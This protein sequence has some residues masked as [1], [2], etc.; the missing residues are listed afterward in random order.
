MKRILSLTLALLLLFSLCSCKKTDVSTSDEPASSINNSPYD[1]GE[2]LTPD[3]SELL[4]SENGIEIYGKNN[5]SLDAPAD[6]MMEVVALIKNTND[7]DVEIVHG[8]DTDIN[9]DNFSGSITNYCNDFTAIV[10]PNGSDFV[11]EANSEMTFI[12]DISLPTFNNQDESLECDMCFT[13]DFEFENYESGDDVANITLNINSDIKYWGKEERS[14]SENQNATIKGVIVDSNN[15]PISNVEIEYFNAI[16]ENHET[17]ISDNNGVFEFK[18]MA[19][20][21]NVSKMWHECIVTFK[22]PSYAETSVCAYPKSNQTTELTIVLDSPSAT[23]NYTEVST[24]DLGIQAYSYDTDSNNS[25]IAFTPFHS[26]LHYDNIKNK[27]NLN[28]TDYDGNLLFKYSLNAETPWVCVSDDGKYVVTEQ[29]ISAGNEKSTYII[30]LDENGK[31]V[32]KKSLTIKVNTP[33]GV[34]EDVIHSRCAQLSHDNKYLIVGTDDG[35]VYVLDWKNDTILWTYKT[36]GQ[37]RNIAFTEDNSTILVSSG[38]NYIYSF[39]IDGSLNFKTFV[40]AWA[41]DMELA[42]D[43]LVYTLKTSWNAL[44]AIDI[45]SGEIIWT[46]QTLARGS[47]LAVSKDNKYVWWGNDVSSAY[48]CI[49]NAVFNIE[50]GEVAYVLNHDAGQEAMYSGDGKY[51]VVKTATKLEVFETTNYSCV[52]QKDIVDP[53]GENAVSINQTVAVN[54]DASKIV[55]CFN[56]DPSCRFYGQAYYFTL[57]N[58]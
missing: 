58:S 49:N 57:E 7:F 28:F 2:T 1:E 55:A 18:V 37:I 50:T 24:I 45:T 6:G 29:A 11:I 48:S 42:G 14:N 39:N 16:D 3:F 9:S 44:G 25:V 51:L 12:V 20:K 17:V 31:E 56:N 13:Y 46:Y 34:K 4:G 52:F 15:N 26:G 41:T 30:V 38:D 21:S 10:H 8:S 5:L 35:D 54:Y 19:H 23:L 32:Y 43:K 22:H 33:Q 36:H 47:G 40:G 53:N 27:V